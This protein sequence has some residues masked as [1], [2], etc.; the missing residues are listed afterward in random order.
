MGVVHLAQGL[1]GRRVA[2]KVLRPAVIGDDEARER[3]AREVASL[4]RV[5][6]PRI[7]EVI[8]ADPWGDM[9][10]VATRYVPGLSLHQHVREQGPVSGADLRHLAVGLMEAVLAIHRVGVLHRDIKPSN[11]VLEGR[12]P[13]LIDFGLAR[14]AEDP[15]L[16]HTGWLMGTPGYLAPEILYGEDATVASDVHAWAATVAFAAMGHPPF[17]T[18]PALAVMDRVRRGEHDLAGVPSWLRPLLEACLQPDSRHRPSPPQVL[19]ALLD[20]GGPATR[21]IVARLPDPDPTYRLAGETSPRTKPVEALATTGV[22]TEP[23]PPMPVPEGA[24]YLPPLLRSWRPPP[25]GLARLHRG[26]VQ[27]GLLGIVATGFALAPYLM[28]LYLALVV[29]A[30]RTASW[31]TESALLRQHARGRRRWYDRTLTVTSTPW[32]LIVAT[33][34]TLL[35]LGWAALLALALAVAYLVFRLPMMPGLL[36]AGMVLGLAIWWGPGARRVRVPTRRLL[37]AVTTRHWAGWLCVGLC[38]AGIAVLAGLL[39]SG[40]ADWSPAAGAPWRP[41]TILGDL[42]RWL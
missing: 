21:P 22:L 36:C 32:Y 14:L 4:R 5:V 7:A 11:V 9:P 31:T 35:L 41:G 39:A 27:A 20:P 25:R 18:G 38:A 34:G 42:W 12:S 2:L 17:G 10:F 1:D 8:D 26:L 37:A 29:L 16:T 30:V 19:A 28:L 40:G 13:V 3:L 33:G 15:R 23:G 6:S 24:P